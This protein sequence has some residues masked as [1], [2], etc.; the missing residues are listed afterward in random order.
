VL[1]TP[2]PESHIP[3]WEQE[4]SAGALCQN[5]LLAAHAHGFV[6]NWLTG[7]PAY[8][9]ALAQLL[10][11]QAG[12]RIAGLIYIGTPLKALDERPRPALAQ[13]VHYWQG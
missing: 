12:A 5:L 7:W 13:V 2:K 3:L 1:S 8:C 10:C 4:L 6:A 11:P 9:A